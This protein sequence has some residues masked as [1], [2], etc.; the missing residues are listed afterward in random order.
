MTTATGSKQKQYD[1]FASSKAAPVLE[2]KREFRLESSYRSL[3][4]K[5]WQYFYCPCAF[6]WGK[7]QQAFQVQLV[8]LSFSFS[9]HHLCHLSKIC[10]CS[11]TKQIVLWR[12]QCSSSMC[13]TWIFWKWSSGLFSVGVRRG[14]FDSSWAPSLSSASE[15]SG[16]ECKPLHRRTISWMTAWNISENDDCAIRASLEAAN[17]SPYRLKRLEQI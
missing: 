5:T 1:K 3:Q 7:E 14:P 2:A 13:L 17:S 6:L 8:L 15:A 16:E 9:S 10:K 11:V 12:S 4:I